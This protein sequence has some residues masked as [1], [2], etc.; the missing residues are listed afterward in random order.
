MRYFYYTIDIRYY[1]TLAQNP[2]IL[3][4]KIYIYNCGTPCLVHYY[5][6]LSL[7]FLCPAVEKNV[8]K[9]TMQFTLSLIW[10][11][12][13]TRAPVTGFMKFTNFVAS[14]FVI[15]INISLSDLYPVVGWTSFCLLILQ[16]KCYDKMWICKIVFVKCSFL[17]LL[18]F[19]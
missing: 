9:K 6:I 10:P 18:N 16:M 19:N 5:Y 13:S 7:S 1:H 15:M 2:C 4:V 12:P 14:P 17:S 8:F 3:G 11:R